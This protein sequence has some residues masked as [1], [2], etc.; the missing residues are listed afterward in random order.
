MRRI[1]L[2]LAFLIVGG[3]AMGAVYTPDKLKLLA[4]RP[5]IEKIVI[6]GN[7][8]FSEGKIKKKLYSRQDGF[9]QSVGLKRRNL[10]TKTNLA[11][12]QILLE[13]FYK[14]QGFPDAK[15]DVDFSGNAGKTK[16]TIFIN[17]TEGLRYRIESVS[18]SGLLGPDLDKVTSAANQL[19]PKEYLRQTI[20]ESVRQEI[21][22]Y[23]ANTGYPYSQETD[24][25][26]RND[27]DSTVKISIKINKGDRVAFGDLI[28]DSTITTSHRVF[29]HEVT[30]KRGD[31]YSR[32]KLFESEQRLIRT[33][34][35]SYVTLRTPDS[36]SHVDSLMP[37][38]HVS[39]FERLPKYI[40][41]A[42]GANQDQE[43]DF[44][45]ALT[46]IVGNRNIK[47]TGRQ[48]SLM[49]VT[50]FQAFSNWG[51]VKQHFEYS[52]TEPYSFGLRMP[53]TFAFR[54][55]PAVRS[56]IQKYRIQTVGVDATL[57]REFSL[58][59]K[60]SVS[61]TYEQ[62]RIFDVDTAEARTYINELGLNVDRKITLELDVDTRPLLN[63]FNPSYGA[64]TQYQLTYVGGILGGTNS[65]VEG[66]WSWS[67]YNKF[68]INGVFAS[69]I[70]LGW[71]TEFGR[72]SGVPTKD[73]FYLGGAYTLRGFPE[74]EFGPKDQNG[75]F[76]G[77]ESM[78]LLNLELRKPL[79]WQ[80]WGSTFV[81]CGYNVAEITDLSF[82]SPALTFGAGIQW[83]SPV[84]PI[85]LD[86]GQRT[87]INHYPP[88]GVFHWSILYA[89]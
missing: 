26:F 4:K 87:T 36:M 8:S 80:I 31:I 10:F 81:D 21:K 5:H 62:F 55:E 17:I 39:A 70:K 23:F 30:F 86:Y 85:R 76:I 45:W 47:G 69:R 11:Y 19:R 64:L 65:F 61:G 43:K 42:A 37:P 77:G 32:D 38:F 16:A 60:L 12:D 73:K 34:L 46:G 7:K 51:F 50:S 41:L 27:A 33:N 88:G 15:V 20:R 84:G 67:K 58:W 83:M 79:F 9:W 66:V 59:T 63:K 49:S 22:T 25:L 48:M 29:E 6:T 54:Y 40:N 44:L 78:G 53:L 2:V 72:S 57:T 75:V 52:Y 56:L 13:Y 74:N 14:D 71:I 89:F 3:G 28:I 18:V 1:A 82:R 35:F 24:S 68:D